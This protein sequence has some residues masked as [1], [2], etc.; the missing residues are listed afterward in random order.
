MAYAIDLDKISIE[1]YRKLMDSR[2]H[3]P[4]QDET[5]AKAAGMTVEG[6]RALSYREYR[7][8]VRDLV[9]ATQEPLSDPN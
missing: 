8:L 1:E 4:A 6:V 2:M 3:D 5:L 7:K 9:K